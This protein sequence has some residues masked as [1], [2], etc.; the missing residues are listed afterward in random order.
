MF[1]RLGPIMPQGLSR[2]VAAVAVVAVAAGIGVASAPVASAATTNSAS[3][4]I[5]L[6]A[7][8]IYNYRSD[9]CMD[10][11][12]GSNQAIQNKCVESPS[13]ATQVWETPK[14][15]AGYIILEDLHANCI[16]I[17]GASKAQGA[18]AVI[19]SCANTANRQWKVKDI[20]TINGTQL[21]ELVNRNSGLCLTDDH[22]STAAGEELN[23]STCTGNAAMLWFELGDV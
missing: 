7:E 19:T 3:P 2:R 20:T 15:S 12:S 10:I 11:R 8:H 23:Q 9:L 14:N 1:N 21:D 5:I 17:N 13:P 16:G 4:N 6:Y 18:P 22:G